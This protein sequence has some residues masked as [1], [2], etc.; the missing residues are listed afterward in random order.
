MLPTILESDHLRLTAVS[1]D[2][3][4][5][6]ISHFSQ[7][8]LTRR[9]HNY[10]LEESG[11]TILCL[12]YRHNGIGSNSCGPELF[13]QYRLEDATICFVIGIYPEHK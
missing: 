6:N 7:E 5:F 10:E 8:E 12:D 4:S 3:F 1:L 11:S 2:W 9:L 13:E